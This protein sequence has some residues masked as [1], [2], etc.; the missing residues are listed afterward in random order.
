MRSP[1]HGMRSIMFSPIRHA[2]VRQVRATFNDQ[3]KGE[4][5]VPSSSEA[6]F[7]PGSVIRRVHGDVTAMMVGGLAALLTQML[8]P[9]ALGGVW[10]HSDAT[11]DQL[12]RLRRTAR[13]IALTTYGHRDEAL[14]AISRV[15]SIHQEVSGTLADGQSYR[16]SDPWLLAWV[17]VAGA[18]NFL[19]GWQRY[20]EP[21]MSSSDQDR[22]F[23]ESGEIARL[24]EADPIP[25]TRDEAERLIAAFRQELRSDERTRAFRDLVV[26]S[27]ARSSHEAPVQRLLMSAA[28]D[29]MPPF[30]RR[31]HGLAPPVMPP[32]VRGATLGLA[33]TIRWAFA[34]EKYR[35]SP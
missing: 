35:N 33:G 7:P 29:L 6:L 19:A 13:F 14:A 11:E 5:P 15:K 24:L 28:V 3:S 22:Y 30:A 26:E 27:K 32:L 10:D 9:K 17:H 31:M 34:G 1:P 25:R 18:V 21:R 20:A 8:H 12:G 23:A 2:L 4:R 16:A